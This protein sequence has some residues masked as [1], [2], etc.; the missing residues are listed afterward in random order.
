MTSPVCGPSRY[1]IL[2]P[3]ALR[4]EKYSASS[5]AAAAAAYASSRSHSLAV[6]EFPARRALACSALVGSGGWGEVA[7]LE[8]AQAEFLLD[9]AAFG[10]GALAVAVVARAAAVLA[11]GGGHDVD[12]VL[13]VAHRDPP[14][15]GVVTVGGDA[16]GVH[17]PAG[18]LGPL[19]VG[20][21]AVARRGAH[22]AVPHVLGHLLAGALLAYAHGLVEV[23]GQFAQEGVVLV[24]GCAAGVGDAGHGERG[25]DVGVGVFVA[26]ARTE[27]V[28][29]QAAAAGA[30][31]DVRH[32][33]GTP[34]RRVPGPG[35]RRGPGRGPRPGRRRCGRARCRC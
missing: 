13:G 5:R 33:G 32:H 17:D 15:G 23:V 12:V 34:K 16:G 9:L 1:L 22:G 21:I 4:F 10:L 27:K 29:Q 7:G 19:L 24:Q 2:M 31:G 28:G 30:G 25:H 3:R 11:H 14:A 35:G 8:A 18:D 6:C 26:A 20:Q